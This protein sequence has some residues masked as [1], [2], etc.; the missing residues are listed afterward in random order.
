MTSSARTV[1]RREPLPNSL[2]GM[3]LAIASEL[4]LFAGLISAFT[5]SKAGASAGTWTMPS[6]P[7]LP[8]RSTALNTMA[9]LASGV[10]VFV[11]FRQ[12][13]HRS[14][15]ASRT[16]LAAWGL[17]AA[18]VVL[19]G[20]EWWGLL[21]RGLT[22]YSSGLG[23]FFYLI[24]GTHAVHAVCALVGLGVAWIRLRRGTL[25]ASFFLGAQVFW[26]FVVGIW[27]VIYGRVY[28]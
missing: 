9:L 6:E 27:P 11:A 4:M 21:S 3:L 7:L 2:V 5:I 16:L 26:Y 1:S 17:G 18:F 23:A 15:S 22:M 25:S 24:V 19:Q 13:Q 20:R 8:V 10:L 12:F 14:A 28:F